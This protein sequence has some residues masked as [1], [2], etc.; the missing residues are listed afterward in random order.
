MPKNRLS[1]KFLLQ[2]LLAVFIGQCCATAWT[3]HD[4]R[5]IQE[6][7]IRQKV[8]LSTKQLAS[9]AAISRASFDFTYLGQ[10]M[11]QVLKDA[12]VVRIAYIDQTGFT[13]MD[14]KSSFSGEPI[15]LEMP[16]LAGT[17]PAG[18][19]VVRYTFDRVKGHV[20]QHLMALAVIQGGVFIALGLLVFYFFRRELGS[21]IDGMSSNIQQVISGD[22]TCRVTASRDDELGAIASGLDILVQWLSSTVVKIRTIAGNVSDAMNHL[23]KTFKDVI[24]GVNRQQLSTENGLFSVQNALDSLEQVIVSTDNLLELS[25]ES[26]SALNEILSASQGIVTKIDRLSNEVHASFE[27]VMTLSRTAKDVAA[28]AGRASHSMEDATDAV[29]KINESVTRVDGIVAETTEL[30]VHTTSIIADRG[31]NSVNDA[32][33]SMQ[34]IEGL[35]G[36]VTATI[37]SLGAR[38]KDIAKVLDVIKEVT[39]Q[40]KLLSLNAQILSGQAGEYGK[41][42]AV[43]ASEMK[44]LSDKTAVSTKEIEAIVSTI[45]N[46][47]NAA[48]S[49]T[50]STVTMV[51]EGKAVAIRASEALQGIQESSQRSTDMVKNIESVAAE[52]KNNL[53][54]IVDAFSQIRQLISEVNRATTQE[55]KIVETLLGGF[56]SFRD[57]MEVTRTASEDQVKSI[58]L[59]SENLALAREKTR[60]IA[61]STSQQREVNEEMIKSMKRIIQIGAETVNGVRDVSARIVTISSEVDALYREIQTFRTPANQPGGASAPEQL[62]PL[63]SPT[64]RS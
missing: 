64:K 11:D 40:T 48:V 50:R 61:G 44:S 59:I 2:I 51:A 42:F 55:E 35:V 8:I 14:K 62:S 27:T 18:R 56:T 3:I 46:E 10:L 28:I 52:Q 25:E 38:S 45:Q 37:S 31:I 41:P 34:K 15:T 7:N 60:A 6:E 24:S 12:D 13:V 5:K 54:Q 63:S 20:L 16:V 49:S 33:G 57:A 21:R 19:M 17:E 58:Q 9:I 39:E 47:I 29:T 4:N 1:R 23:N 32:I 22:L 53:G 30:S 43:V 26:S 36:S